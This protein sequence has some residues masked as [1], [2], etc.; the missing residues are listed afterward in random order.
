VEGGWAKS[1]EPPK[2]EEGG[3][4]FC[5][6]EGV[7]RKEGVLDFP[8][9]VGDANRGGVDCLGV[10]MMVGGNAGWFPVGEKPG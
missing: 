5:W 4:L 7:G 8:N 6:T 9:G 3:G 10:D 1:D 2:L